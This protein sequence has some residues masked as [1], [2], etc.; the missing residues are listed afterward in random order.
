[1]RC[2]E[3]GCRERKKESVRG[4]E[5]KKKR[6]MDRERGGESERVIVWGVYFMVY[7]KIQ[8]II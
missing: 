8:V 7:V 4:G 3:E 6:V 2:R 5:G 1:L